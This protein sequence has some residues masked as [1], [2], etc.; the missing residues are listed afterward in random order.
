MKNPN[1]PSVTI[2]L[3]AFV[4]ASLASC[5]Q[6]WSGSSADYGP[7]VIDIRASSTRKANPNRYSVLNFLIP[8]GPHPW[9]EGKRGSGVGESITFTLAKTSLIRNLVIK[10]GH[11]KSFYSHN[12]VRT[13]KISTDSGKQ[14]NVT[15][16]NMKRPQSIHL[17]KDFLAKELRFTILSVYRRNAHTAI[18]YI[19]FDYN[20]GS[21]LGERLNRHI[22]RITRTFPL[23]AWIVR[24]RARRAARKA[25]AKKKAEA[26]EKARTVR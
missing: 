4:L 11:G 22:P 7:T 2:V 1:T 10:N 19:N 14:V 25:E 15:L 24:K 5:G 12:R 21:G 9:I 16:K 17:P 26:Q 13:L 18:H 8:D 3:L 23:P 6:A 20:I